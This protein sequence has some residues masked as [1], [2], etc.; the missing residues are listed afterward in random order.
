MLNTF[1]NLTTVAVFRKSDF[2]PMKLENNISVNTVHSIFR[3]L[4]YL[5][6]DKK[7][8]YYLKLLYL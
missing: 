4:H 3:L 2:M 6:L 5:F 1:K 8:V 7:R